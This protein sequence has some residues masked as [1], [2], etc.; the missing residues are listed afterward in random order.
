M[1]LGNKCDLQESRV[2]DQERGKVVSHVTQCPTHPEWQV[3]D[4][5]CSSCYDVILRG[6][7]KCISVLKIA[8]LFMAV[9]SRGAIDYV[10]LVV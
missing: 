2:V 4:G 6:V 7:F 3:V 1:I 10:L 5:K 9:A 8:K